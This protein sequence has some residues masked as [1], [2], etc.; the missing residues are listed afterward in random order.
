[1]VREREIEALAA[2]AEDRERGGGMENHEVETQVETVMTA[3]T[4]GE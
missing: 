3:N 1:M 4:P 2:A